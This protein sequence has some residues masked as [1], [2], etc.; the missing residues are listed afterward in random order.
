MAQT[1]DPVPLEAFFDEVK[2]QL[3]IQLKYLPD[4]AKF[5]IQLENSP[6]GISRNKCVELLQFIKGQVD[7]RDNEI[8]QL[9]ASKSGGKFL[10][11]IS[12]EA[13][14]ALADVYALSFFYHQEEPEE[15]PPP[16]KPIK[17]KK[18]TDPKSKKDQ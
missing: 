6:V 7:L 4:N 13:A 18:S 3:G 2:E 12:M 11:D 5:P 8:G 9:Y 14:M 17:T 16:S 10:L 1:L 15:T